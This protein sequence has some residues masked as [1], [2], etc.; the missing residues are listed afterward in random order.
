MAQQTASDFVLMNGKVITVD[1][2]FTIAEAVAVLG[3]RIIGVGTNEEIAALA[4]P[5][6]TMIDLQ[7][8]ICCPWFD[9]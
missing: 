5:N 3:E 6:T 7:G 9:R 8:T 2:R 4:G 1:D